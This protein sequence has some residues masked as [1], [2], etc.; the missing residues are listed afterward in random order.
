MNEL[1]L[2]SKSTQ[3]KLSESHKVTDDYFLRAL[4]WL[5]EMKHNNNINN[6][7]CRQSSE[8]SNRAIV[9]VCTVYLCVCGRVFLKSVHKQYAL[10][11]H[12]I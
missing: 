2:N 3:F 8:T 12:T 6:Y 10:G 1:I 7:A 5:E 11:I 9:S 4:L